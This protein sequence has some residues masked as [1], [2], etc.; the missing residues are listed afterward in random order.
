MF[1]K[2]LVFGLFFSKNSYFK[3]GWNLLDFI[4][5]LCSFFYYTSIWTAFDLTLLRTFRFLK[6]LKTVASLKKLQIILMALFAAVPLLLDVFIILLFFFLLY[7]IAGLQL[8]SG[9][10]KNRCMQMNTG[11]INV[12]TEEICGNIQCFS[13]FICVKGLDNI[14]NGLISF[15]N[16]AASFLQVL[17]IITLD[18]W[19]FIMYNI[20]KGVT[21]YAWV[22]FISLVIIGSYVLTNLTLAVIKVKFSEI[23][24]ELIKGETRKK[25][26]IEEFTTYDF[27]IIKRQGL[28]YH[29]RTQNDDISK[30]FIDKIPNIVTVNVD[31]LR[32]NSDKSSRISPFH[33]NLN[34]NF[35]S[36]IA[37]KSSFMNKRNSEI[38]QNNTNFAKKISKGSNNE[39]QMICRASIVSNLEFEEESSNLFK[40]TLRKT[41]TSLNQNFKR[42]FLRFFNY[43]KSKRNLTKKTMLKIKPKYLKLIIDHEKE[44][45]NLSAKEVL[46]S[47]DENLKKILLEKQITMIKK[48]KLPIVYTMR[49]TS[50]ILMDLLRKVQE[51]NGSI[52]KEFIG[53]ES[54]SND[55]FS[56]L[57]KKSMRSN[58]NK[59]KMTILPVSAAKIRSSKNFDMLKSTK[60]KNFNDN[61]VVLTVKK[62]EKIGSD[63]TLNSQM[64]S[65]KNIIKGESMNLGRKNEGS[66]LN[67]VQNDKKKS[68]R[69]SQ[70]NM[71]L[72]EINFNEKENN[73]G[74]FAN[75]SNNSREKE[76]NTI[77]SKEKNLNLK[78]KSINS[79]EKRLTKEQEVMVSL[80]LGKSKDVDYNFLSIIINAPIENEEDDETFLNE[81]K[82][83]EMDIEKLYLKIRVFMKK[84]YRVF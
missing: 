27:N 50:N 53:T 39:E 64:K 72:K 22:Y 21:N 17:F 66:F 11:L 69:F 74:N 58:N 68:H 10:L 41:L 73:N 71:G 76:K 29:K 13:G 78:E 56:L 77:N 31:A 33:S 26:K 23:H 47:H 52:T 38:L 19:T 36:K 1:L 84:I 45:E 65:T 15:D 30:R 2:I 83:D 44:L 5:N 20:Q 8:F 59:R 28:W 82:E 37:S 32:E 16:L 48:A 7:A 40:K 18:S 75:N 14:T 63:F 9:I 62:A 25:K 70:M 6:P 42:N 24:K 43:R 12:N 57:H 60:S 55:L 67:I 3:E 49:K 61:N 46:P 80:V 54:S 81:L 35:N 79:N 51:K 34:S 4:V